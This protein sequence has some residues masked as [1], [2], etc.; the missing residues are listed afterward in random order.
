MVLSIT[1]LNCM[2]EQ[3]G[4]ENT[5]QLHQ[6]ILFKSTSNRQVRFEAA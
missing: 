5:G 6:K 1:L 2:D 4:S 3:R